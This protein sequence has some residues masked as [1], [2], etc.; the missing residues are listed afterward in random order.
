L[1]N[2][3]N[4]PGEAE[5]AFSRSV[6]VALK[7]CTS[8]ARELVESLALQRLLLPARAGRRLAG[9]GGGGAARAAVPGRRVVS[10]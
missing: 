9:L 1:T 6:V 8:Q 7:S 2:L 5:P 10:A 3:A 4:A